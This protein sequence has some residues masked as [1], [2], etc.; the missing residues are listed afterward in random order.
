MNPFLLFLIF[1]PLLVSLFLSIA[2]LGVIYE[3]GLS[4][5]M[6]VVFG[7]MSGICG[8]LMYL[9]KKTL[10]LKDGVLQYPYSESLTDWQKKRLTSLDLL[11]AY[12]AL[13]IAGLF[14]FDYELM[15]GWFGVLAFVMGLILIWSA[16]SIF[17]ASK[18][19]SHSYEFQASL[20]FY[21]RK[22]HFFYIFAAGLGAI[23]LLSYHFLASWQFIS[24]W[25]IAGI[26]FFL[27]CSCV[28]LALSARKQQIDNT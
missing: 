25:D 17:R 10:S 7:V 13:T 9:F 20:A 6:V 4:V 26:L 27:T 2:F 18:S 19:L 16:I 28:W 14:L 22:K 24:P 11:S 3:E 12:T 5:G 1:I 15:K 21:P 8:Y 23:I